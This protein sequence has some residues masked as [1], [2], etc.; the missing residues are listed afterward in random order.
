MP[1]DWLGTWHV[2]PDL[3]AQ[4][5]PSQAVPDG[6]P[7]P[8]NGFQRL[9]PLAAADYGVLPFFLGIARIYSPGPVSAR[10]PE[11]SPPPGRRPERVV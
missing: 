2:S 1:L 11:T 5:E 3:R 10:S 4:C 7:M 6:A 9:D 8:S